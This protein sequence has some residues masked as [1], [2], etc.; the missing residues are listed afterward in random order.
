MIM[1]YTLHQWL[2]GILSFL[3]IF[4]SLLVIFSRS[5]VNSVI[6]LVLAFFC[7]SGH[8]LLMNA[9]F[10][11][12]VNIVVYAGAIM[13]LFLFIIMLMNLNENSEPQKTRLTKLIAGIS[14]GLLLLSLVRILVGAE[15]LEKNYS[16]KGNS[17]AGN[18]D[19]IADV[20]FSEFLF[21][22]EIIS[23]LLLAALVGA[24]FLGKKEIHVERTDFDPAE[25]SKERKEEEKSGARK[26]K[27]L[28]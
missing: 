27:T 21:P 2:F 19:R 23:V 20:L 26:E 17:Q 28:I 3:T 16:L 9:Q 7:I 5:P 22:F 8:Y 15:I 1:G 25:D 18:M 10:L 24:V 11:A 13:V 12:V 4:F 6:Y 14:G